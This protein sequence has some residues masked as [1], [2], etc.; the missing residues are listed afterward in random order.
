MIFDRRSRVNSSGS[1]GVKVV[2]GAAWLI[3]V[4]FSGCQIADPVTPEKDEISKFS[5]TFGG[6]CADF[7][8]SVRQTA[9]GGFILVG[10]SDSSGSG[11]RDLWLLKSDP[12]GGEEWHLFHGGLQLDSGR[13][14]RQTTDGGFIITGVTMSIG[15]GLKDLWLLKVSENG[16]VEWSRTFGGPHQDSGAAVRQTADGGYI[17]TGYT[18]SF[19]AGL[20]DLWL[21]KTDAAG[22]TAWT[23]IYGGAGA[24]VGSAVVETDGGG[25]IVA[26]STESFGSGNS[27]AWL[28]AVDASGD[29]EWSQVYGGRGWDFG[30]ALEN[31]ADGGFLV[32]GGS[33]SYGGG[34]QDV[35]LIRTDPEGTVLF[36]RTYGGGGADA[37]SSVAVDGL[38]GYVVTG[39]TGSFGDG[40]DDIWLIG[41]SSS[42]ARLWDRTFGGGRFDRGSSVGTT[43]D[44]GFIIAGYTDSFGAGKYDAWLI[45]TDGS[46]VPDPPPDNGDLPVG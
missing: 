31:T 37:G 26:G 19:G 13:D 14:V 3:A 21:L 10:G 44:G 28:I 6:D 18:E 23:R 8:Y 2:L 29:T 36:S 32:A 17:I 9:D 12:D 38:G 42:G 33:D 27:D 35:W 7:G 20:S 40:F 43:L 4:L 5:R 39:Y 1:P 45:K 25:F 34:G 30:M 15:S 46:D 11:S 24:D 41:V 16:A 22:D